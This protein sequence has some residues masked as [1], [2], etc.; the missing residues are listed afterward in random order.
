MLL[1]HDRLISGLWGPWV[2]SNP[3]TFGAA[4]D[5]LAKVSSPAAFAEAAGSRAAKRAGRMQA[6]LQGFGV[7]CLRALW[8]QGFNLE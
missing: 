5:R 1:S 2:T 4:K 8:D 7:V 3:N 6:L